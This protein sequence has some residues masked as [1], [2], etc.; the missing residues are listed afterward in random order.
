MEYTLSPE[1]EFA[2]E[3]R[4]QGIDKVDDKHYSY[5]EDYYFD[6]YAHFGIHEDM[7]KDSVRTGTYKNAIMRNAFLFKD[8]VVL[9]VGCGTGILSFFAARAGARQVYAVDCADIIDFTQKIV[10]K[11]GYSSQITVIKG[12]VEEIEVPEQVDIIISEWMGYFLLYESMLDSVLFARDKWLKPGGMLFPDKA[13]LWL[14]AIEDAK[15]KYEK[16]DFWTDVYG[17]DMNVMRREALLEPVV[18]LVESGNMVSSMCPVFEIDLA[19]VTKQDLTFTSTYKLHINRKD[20]V[21]ALV[22]WFEVGFLHCHKPLVLT[23][24][25]KQKSTH[26]K[27]T[28][29]YLDNAHPV[30]SGEVL[31]GSIAV[32]PNPSHPRELDIK[33]S[34]NLE[35]ETPLH[36]WQFYRLR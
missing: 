1:A 25:P 27:Q 6:S 34:Y 11:N 29:F 21:H 17:I 4:W 5:G 36:T 30:N 32:R 13:R 14:A 18:D 9:D 19:T 33:I 35:G 31:E 2:E 7:I 10:E 28:I 22:G 24:S 3:T 15:Y 26:W 20:F 8:K 12:K 23:T 16:I